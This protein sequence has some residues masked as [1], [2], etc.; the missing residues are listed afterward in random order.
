MTVNKYDVDEKNTKFSLKNYARGLKYLK[1]YRWQ[2]IVLFVIDT[3]VMLSYLL[4][5]KQIQYILDNAVGT[6]NYVLVIKSILKIIGLV[7]IYIL[8]DLIEKRKMLKINQLIVV[9]IKN[10][11]FTHI[12]NLTFQYFDTRPNGKIIVRLTEYAAG[13]ADLITDKLLTTVFLILNMGLTFIF[14]ITTNAKLTLIII[15]GVAV[16]SIILAVTAKPKRNMR[17]NINNKYSNYA[18]YRL[19]NLKGIE[20]IQ[21]FNRQRKNLENTEKLKDNFNIARKRILPLSNTGWFSVQGIEHIV[22]IS[23]SFI[24]AYYLYPSI[25]AGTIIAMGEYSYNFWRPIKALFDMIDD[26]IE[27]MTYLERILETMDEPITIYDSKNAKDVDINGKIEFKNVTFS[28]LQG[29]TVLEKMNFEVSPKEKVA[30]VG[31]TGSGKTTISNLI[32]RFYDIDSG[33]INIDDINIKDMKLKSLR[34]Q[35]TVM[36]QE[37]YL[38]STTIMENL[39]YG[40][41]GLSNEDVI[42]ACKKMNID[43][44]IN[45]FPEGYNTI[46]SGNA[47]NLS[48][49]ERQILCYARTIINNPKILIFDEA[50]SKMDT[51]TEK[52]LQELT[53]EM[54][55]D[56][57]L[58]VIAHRLSTIINSDKIYFLKD[59]KIVE[60]GSHAELMARKGEYY[61]LYMS[62]VIG[63]C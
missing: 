17:L 62:Q 61:N 21:V 9:D 50:T 5:T 56:K 37:N 15:A 34:S 40:N 14:M 12:E 16:L 7:L 39:K 13:V 63:E 47:S 44:W 27:A 19:E 42:N 59:K 32:C 43:S 30:I 54:I 38:F 52:V 11:L 26:F 55:K 53:K 24:G 36:Q 1:K 41:D 60:V 35:I 58:I 45:K 25:S 8:F 2:L 31:E 4:I 18:A 23:I 49:G 51:K 46:L 22:T 10:D 48:D 29:N 6:T 33:E 3:I 57:T 20:T 28:Y